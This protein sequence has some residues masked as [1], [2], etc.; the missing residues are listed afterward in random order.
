[1]VIRGISGK[2]FGFPLTSTIIER[3]EE[4]SMIARSLFVAAILMALSAPASAYYCPK[5]GKAIDAA[6][7]KGNLSAAQTAD[8]KRLRD[9]GMAQHGSG[10]HKAAVKSLAEA[11]RIILGGM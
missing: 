11:T 3:L 1:V 4:E 5:Q 2:A 7:A 6:I 8:V 9:Q 10:D